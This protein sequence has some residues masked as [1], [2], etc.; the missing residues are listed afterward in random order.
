MRSATERKQKPGEERHDDG[1]A[2]RKD[3]SL[4]FPDGFH[5]IL[6]TSSMRNLAPFP[7]GEL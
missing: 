5:P 4:Y 7:I 3:V 6:V 2:Y 1:E